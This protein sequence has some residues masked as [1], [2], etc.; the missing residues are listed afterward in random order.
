MRVRAR[1]YALSRTR[2]H[3]LTRFPSMGRRVRRAPNS[4]AMMRPTSVVDGVLSRSC[5]SNWSITVLVK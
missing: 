3:T 2:S 1:G 5:F 4:W